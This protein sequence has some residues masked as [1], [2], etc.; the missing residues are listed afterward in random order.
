MLRVAD[1]SHSAWKLTDSTSKTGEDGIL[2]SHEFWM[3]HGCQWLLLED[4]VFFN[5][6][7]GQL[8]L[9]SSQ[10]MATKRSA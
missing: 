7:P 9:R 2:S 3:I 5:A 8:V 10:V 1:F 6:S 4:R